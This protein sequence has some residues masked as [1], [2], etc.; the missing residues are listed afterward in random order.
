VSDSIT[1]SVEVAVSPDVAFDVFTRDIDAWYRVDTAALPDITRTGA[2]RFEAHLG[3]R[4]LDVYDLA[5]GAG[6]ELGRIT[7]WE[8]G[9]RLV[10]ADNEGTEVDVSF[11]PGGAGTRVTLTHRGLDRLT[12]ERAGALR[13]S[14]WAALAPFYRDHVAP[15]ARPVAVAVVVVGALQI[16]MVGALGL[17]LSLSSGLPSWAAV[18]LTAVLVLV[19]G[20][21]VLRTQDRLVRRWLPS[22]WQYERIFYRLLALL[23]AGLLLNNLHAVIVDGG[24]GD[25]L[26]SLALPVALLL[27]YWSTETQGPARGESLRKRAAPAEDGLARRQAA[28]RRYRILILP[29][30]VAVGIVAEA[31]SAGAAIPILWGAYSLKTIYAKRRER[32]TLG[33]DPD[34]YLAVDRPVSEGSRPPDLLVHHDSKQP[35][36]SGWYAYA[37][38]RERGSEDL[39]VWSMR[40]LVDHAPEAASALREG[41]GTWQWDPA[42]RAYRRL[43]AVPARGARP[44]ETS[45]ARTLARYQRAPP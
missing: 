16:A 44:W 9:R 27:W 22:K 19:V 5:T 35:E 11:E 7:T 2:I 20:V 31:F 23:S 21:A 15:N 37:T 38:E 28:V 36:Y 18:S 26:W 4:L 8:P 42:Q 29:V 32:R 39:I 3:G 12:P 40:D 25:A 13:R 30:A 43:G 41:H 45:T 24:N 33:F 6:R 10:F 14:G 34:L 17:G 1:T